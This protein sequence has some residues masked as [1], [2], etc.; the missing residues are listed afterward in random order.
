MIRVLCFYIRCENNEIINT[1]FTLRN[2]ITVAVYLH[3]PLE[4]MYYPFHAVET[5]NKTLDQGLW[6]LYADEL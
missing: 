6:N 5:N 3:R 4:H 1:K 2:F